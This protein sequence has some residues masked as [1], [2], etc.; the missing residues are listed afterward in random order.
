VVATLMGRDGDEAISAELLAS[1]AQTIHYEL[2][3]R[4]GPHLERRV[5]RAAVS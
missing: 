2:L 1:W 3:S 5:M 4:L